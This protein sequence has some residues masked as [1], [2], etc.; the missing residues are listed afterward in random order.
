MATLMAAAGR[1]ERASFGFDDRVLSSAEIG[2][3]VRRHKA[4]LSTR[5]VVVD[6]VQLMTDEGER[7]IDRVGAA[8]RGLVRLARTER[9]AVLLLS[10][11]SRL[12]EREKR[13]PQLSDLRESGELEQAARMVLFVHQETD[14]RGRFV[15]TAEILVAKN[16]NG[17][18]HGLVQLAWDANR[19]TFCD[20]V[21]PVWLG[22]PLREPEARRA[23]SAKEDE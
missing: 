4:E 18:T 22:G 8:L 7:T 11:L 23:G 14:D 3:A 20:L 6:Y 13:R 19:A 1:L 21:E 2:T 15:G 12:S 16:S 9:V 17:P 5:L 10:Q